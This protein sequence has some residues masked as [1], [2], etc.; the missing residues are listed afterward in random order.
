[1]G[2]CQRC[3]EI[4]VTPRC[5]CG[6]TAKGSSAIKETSTQLLFRGSPGD[7]WSQRITSCRVFSGVCSAPRISGSV[8]RASIASSRFVSTSACM[9][10]EV[11]YP[12]P[13]AKVDAQ[14]SELYFCREC[15]ADRFSK[16]TCKKCKCA[17]LSDAPFIRHDD[18]LW[19]ELFNCRKDSDP[20][21]GPV[22]DFAGN[23]SCE[24]CFDSEAYK[25]KGVP[26][27]PH[28]AQKGFEM[29]PVKAN[30]RPA[31]SKWGGSKAKLNLSPAVKPTTQTRYGQDHSNTPAGNRNSA[32]LAG[33]DRAVP[34]WRL[35]N[36]REKSPIAASLDEMGNTFRRL[37]LERSESPLASSKRTDIAAQ[38]TPVSSP[39][40]STYGRDVTGTPAVRNTTSRTAPVWSQVPPINK[41][42]QP[43]EGSSPTES[44]HCSVC[45]LVLGYGEFVQLQG[46][47]GVMHKACFLCGGCRKPLEQGRHIEAGG[48]I[49]HQDCA[50]PPKMFRT[51]ETSLAEPQ[52]GQPRK[53][54][55]PTSPVQDPCCRS[56][57][58]V[59]GLGYNIST[60]GGTVNYCAQCFKCAACSQL[61]GGIPSHRSF[62]E[63]AGLPYH[64]RCAPPPSPKKAE[65]NPSTPLRASTSRAPSSLPLAPS[66]TKIFH[67][68]PSINSAEKPRSIFATRERPP[69]NL[70]GLLVCAG[71]SVRA[72]ERETKSGPLGKRYHPRCL[73][74]GL[75][76]RTVDSE[77]RIGAN[78]ELRCES[79]R[80]IEARRSTNP[81]SSFIHVPSVDA[82]PPR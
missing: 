29:G 64:T 60:S 33:N 79:C 49:W 31:P 27:S 72:T 7:K 11:I 1:M 56:C 25:T 80:K 34:G 81:R 18:R 10:E 51:I 38:S 16:G 43:K 48:Q 19:H 63:V 30:L 23:P 77:S 32:L 42:I 5:K 59:L 15:F 8:L 70:G 45:N 12:H 71:C 22:I 3:G 21:T 14:L 52:L 37:G 39:T 41:S 36:E 74:C 69:E 54:Y 13:N 46:K 61:F 62:I 73:K 28:L 53:P 50:P 24:A 65:E 66:Q 55:V 17:V 26:P 68:P 78:G 76:S 82:T 58:L 2:F 6:G 44:T 47:A 40:S 67:T 35:R 20:Q 9:G 4:T 57:R 75:C